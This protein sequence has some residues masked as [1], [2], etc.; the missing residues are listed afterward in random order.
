MICVKL[1]LKDTSSIAAKK[2]IAVCDRY[3]F[4]KEA[5][6]IYCKFSE[7]DQLITNELTKEELEQVKDIKNII[8]IKEA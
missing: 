7:I 8:Q 4:Q 5:P 2:I 3:K 1:D 6:F